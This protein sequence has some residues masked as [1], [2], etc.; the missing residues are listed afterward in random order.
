M[1][2]LA[3]WMPRLRHPA[4]HPPACRAH[5]RVALSRG[6]LLVVSQRGSGQSRW[7]RDATPYKAESKRAGASRPSDGSLTKAKSWVRSWRLGP[8]GLQ[9][10]ASVRVQPS[11]EHAARLLAWV[12]E[13]G[14]GLK[15]VDRP[16]RCPRAGTEYRIHGTWY[17]VH[18]VVHNTRFE[19]GAWPARWRRAGIDQPTTGWGTWVLSSPNRSRAWGPSVGRDAG[20]REAGSR[21]TGGREARMARGD[22]ACG[23]PPVT[24]RVGAPGL[25]GAPRTTYGGP[26]SRC[27]SHHRGV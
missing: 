4:S 5:R 1:V 21:E 17:R 11:W 15:L 18:I 8:C 16:A 19:A 14:P 26:G 12:H 20:G 27:G 25:E 23:D 2:Q 24:P 7:Q 10:A 6:G 13:Q 22:H 3:N 9:M